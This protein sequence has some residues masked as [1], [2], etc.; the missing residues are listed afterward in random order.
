MKADELLGDARMGHSVR[1]VFGFIGFVHNAAGRD[2]IFKLH[3]HDWRVVPPEMK[4]RCKTTF[5]G[6]GYSLGNG[7]GFKEIINLKRNKSRKHV[8]KG[9]K[10]LHIPIRKKVIGP[11]LWAAT[12]CMRSLCTCLYPKEVSAAREWIRGTRG[13]T[14]LLSEKS[15]GG[16]DQR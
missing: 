10:R 15:R 6:L 9:V 8:I 3:Q 5:E 13:R 11:F 1:A 16:L 4:E 14:E 12:N 2:V 7:R